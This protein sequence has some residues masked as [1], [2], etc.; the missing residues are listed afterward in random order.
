MRISVPFCCNT[1]TT[2]TIIVYVFYYKTYC[3]DICC[4]DTYHYIIS[5]YHTLY[6]ITIPYMVSLY[7]MI[8]PYQQI[9]LL[10]HRIGI[11]LSHD[12]ILAISLSH[13]IILAISYHII[14]YHTISYHI[15]P[16]H[17]TSYHIILYDYCIIIQ[18]IV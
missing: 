1:I 9:P 10:Y 6:Y 11:P 7:C 12:I 8:I 13:D 4:S 17:T 14:P 15:I 5:L 3:I 2:H 16:C 18:Y